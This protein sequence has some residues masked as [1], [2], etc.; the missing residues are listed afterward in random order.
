MVRDRLN[1]LLRPL[2]V[3]P[4]LLVL[5]LLSLVWMLV[6]LVSSVV[7]VLVA[8]MSPALF[9]LNRDIAD[10]SLRPR[11]IAARPRRISPVRRVRNDDGHERRIR[12]AS[13]VT[14]PGGGLRRLLEYSGPHELR[15]IRPRAT[16]SC[17]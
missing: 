6:L 4:H 11:P 16:C 15:C 14:K 5:V 8:R 7:V 13:V 1:V 10:Y 3:L 12:V 9:R 17:A 2:F